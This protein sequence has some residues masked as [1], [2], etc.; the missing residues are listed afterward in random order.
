MRLLDVQRGKGYSSI[1]YPLNGTEKS[2][3]LERCAHLLFTWK[4]IKEQVDGGSL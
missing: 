4:S 1:S 2:E 3:F